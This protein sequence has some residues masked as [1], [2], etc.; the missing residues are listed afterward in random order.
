MRA[1]HQVLLPDLSGYGEMGSKFTGDAFIHQVP[2]N[3]WY[4]GALTK[5]YPV[6]IRAEELYILNQFIRQKRAQD[7]APIAIGFGPASIDLLLA[8]AMGVTYEA[9]FLNN[10]L[11]SLKSLMREKDYQV[12]FIPSLIPGMLSHFDFTDLMKIIPYQ[13]TVVNP[14]LPNGTLAGPVKASSNYQG[15]RNNVELILDRDQEATNTVILQKIQLMN[16][17]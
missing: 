12:K 11:I 9:V 16:N 7:E 2:L 6:T 17:R 4:A 10:P 8:G 15:N 13:I 1:G 5:N 14:V 3:I